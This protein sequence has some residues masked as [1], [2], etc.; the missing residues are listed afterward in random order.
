M[1]LKIETDDK[2]K[3]LSLIEE[4]I[5][6][7]ELHSTYTKK[8]ENGCNSVEIIEALRSLPFLKIFVITDVMSCIN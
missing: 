4:A 6:K 8:L 2:K 5:E 7:T 1:Y 3:V